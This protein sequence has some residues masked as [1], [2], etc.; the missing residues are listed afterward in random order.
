MLPAVICF[1]RLAGIVLLGE[2]RGYAAREAHEASPWMT[3]PMLVLVLLCLAVAVCPGFVVRLI[4]LPVDQLQGYA[5]GRTLS[6]LAASDTSLAT[7][8]VMNVGVWIAVGGLAAMLVVL[9]RKNKMVPGPT[10]GC[11]YVL[12]T[13]RLQYTG[14]S[15]AEFLTERLLPRALRPQTFRKGPQGLFPPGSEF[16]AD[17]PDPLREKVYE[18]FFRRWA[19]RFARLRW[20]QQGNL[21]I[22]LVYILILV[23]LALA[24]VSL[25]LGGTS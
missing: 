3:T 24:W 17:S 23:A 20:M 21:H 2:P 11:G 1:V 8:G 4:A 15:F 7:L 6:E 19:D 22:Y 9:Y 12:P 16:R 14:R 18:P 5:P 13:A 10:W 25:R